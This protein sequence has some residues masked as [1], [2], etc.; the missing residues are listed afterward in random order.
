VFTK[1]DNQWEGILTKLKLTESDILNR[2][3]VIIQLNTAPEEFYTK[4]DNPYRR[5]NYEKAA[6]VNCKYKDVWR[7]HGRFHQIDDYDGHVLDHPCGWDIK[8]ARI[9]DVVRAEV[10]DR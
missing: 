4:A 7:R 8:F 2:Y 6:A 9:Y 5:E 10:L 3:D 1:D